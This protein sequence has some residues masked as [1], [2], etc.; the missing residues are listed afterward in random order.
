MAPSSPGAPIPR[1]L[2]WCSWA[3]LALLAA[4]EL[5]VWGV[6]TFVVL[7]PYCCVPSWSFVAQASRRPTQPE[8]VVGSVM[9]GLFQAFFAL[10]IVSAVRTIRT[11]PGDVPSW[12]RSDGASDLHS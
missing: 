1:S 12:L 6:T 10:A 8:V 4:T 3:A 9:L 7:V 11:P 2:A 5:I